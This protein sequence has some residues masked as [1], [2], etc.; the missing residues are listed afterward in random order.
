MGYL[1]CGTN[2]V[3]IDA[4]CSKLMGFDPMKIPSISNTFNINNYKIC[5]FNYEQIKLFLN[6]SEYFINN[7]PKDFIVN[8]KPSNGWKGHIEY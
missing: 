2:P 8:F 1:F 7:I 6:K 3:S 5:N 4:V